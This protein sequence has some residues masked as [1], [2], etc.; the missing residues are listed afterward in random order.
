PDSQIIDYKEALI[1]A[2]MGLLKSK[3]KIN[4]LKSVTGAIKDHSSGK[5][6]RN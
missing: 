3:E 4:C 6:F 2:Y 1:F 5:I